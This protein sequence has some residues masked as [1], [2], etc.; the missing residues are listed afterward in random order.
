[1]LLDLNDQAPGLKID[2]TYHIHITTISLENFLSFCA[3]DDYS[4]QKLLIA[5]ESY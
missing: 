1:M 3:L 5:I 2:H 4:Q